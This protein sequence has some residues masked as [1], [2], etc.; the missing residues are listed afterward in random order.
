MYYHCSQLHKA[1]A[2]QHTLA[3]LLIISSPT[4]SWRLRKAAGIN[5]LTRKA[6]SKV[7]TSTEAQQPLSIT[8]K[9]CPSSELND[10]DSLVQGLGRAYRSRTFTGTVITVTLTLLNKCH[11]IIPSVSRYDLALI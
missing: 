6:L 1:L 11:A 8:I 10:A 3:K 9:Q 2:L 4:E 7:H 5:T